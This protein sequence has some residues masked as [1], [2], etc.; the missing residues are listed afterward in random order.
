[1]LSALPPLLLPWLLMMLNYWKVCIIP[2]L[3]TACKLQPFILLMLPDLIIV[4]TRLFTRYIIL[5]LI[6]I[7]YLF[8]CH[9]PAGNKR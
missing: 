4:L 7:Y 8:F 1:M 2:A 6:Y 9:D 5:P 3:L